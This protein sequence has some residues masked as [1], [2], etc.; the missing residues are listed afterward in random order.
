MEKYAK[1]PSCDLQ[2]HTG[3]VCPQEGHHRGQ[4]L[5]VDCHINVATATTTLAEWLHSYPMP[6]GAHGG[7][8]HASGGDAAVLVASQL[9]CPGLRN[10]GESKVDNMHV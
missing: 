1:S 2:L 10:P 6:F 9:L 8:Q 4:D 7:V 3:E 5:C